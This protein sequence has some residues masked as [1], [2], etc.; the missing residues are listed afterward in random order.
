MQRKSFDVD[1][2][3]SGDG[4]GEFTGYAST[5]DNFDRTNERV[6]KGAFAQHLDDFLKDGFIALNHNW[7]A[8]PIATP[9]EAREDDHGLFVRAAFHST[10]DAQAA[11]TVINE[12]LERNKSVKL[13]IGYEVLADEYVD[14]G[15]LLKNLY[16]YEYSFVTVPANAQ[17]DVTSSKGWPL[18]EQS[19]AVLAAVKDYTD[20]LTHL[21][22]L[23]AKEGRVLSGANRTRIEQAVEALAGAQT[24]L[25]DLLAAT[26]TPKHYDFTAMLAQSA[27]TMARIDEVLSR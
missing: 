9:I 8:L 1:I 18:A 27:L 14:Q 19:D 26:D 7:G 13:S 16:L 15:R 3:M 2:K 4:S 23:R 10:P 25:K 6:V 17:A 12:R 11:R 20:R 22:S 5:F 21:Q 24:A